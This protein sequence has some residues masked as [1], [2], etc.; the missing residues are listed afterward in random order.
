ML[1]G[2]CL[3]E[4]ETVILGVRYLSCN[5]GA[6]V[7]YFHSAGE[8]DYHFDSQDCDMILVSLSLYHIDC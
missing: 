7:F 6:L 1:E 3:I 5:E 8:L 4:G 2:G